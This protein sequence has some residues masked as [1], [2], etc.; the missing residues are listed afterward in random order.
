[1]L[2]PRIIECQCQIASARKAVI[3][4]SLMALLMLSLSCRAQQEKRTALPKFL[5]DV[6]SQRLAYR[7]EPDASAPSG[8]EIQEQ[9]IHPAVGG[10]FDTRRKDEAL[11]RTI[12]SPD[13]QRVLAVYETADK[14]PGEFRIDLYNAEGNFL[15]NLTPPELSGAFSSSVKWSPDGQF[16]AFLGIQDTTPPPIPDLQDPLLKAPPGELPT[17][18]VT[19]ALQPVEVFNTEQ[20]YVCNRDGFDLKAI[21]KRPGLIYFY[22]AWSPSDHTLVALAC[23]E[24]EWN[25]RSPE[26][27]PVGRPRLVYLTG[28]ERLLDDRL[29]EALPVWSPD[30]AKVATAFEYELA[31]YDTSTDGPTSAR[32]PLREP[33][34]A[35]SVSYDRE[36]IASKVTTAGSPAANGY[37]PLSFN[38]VVRLFWLQPERVY[39]QTGFV[40]IYSNEPVSKHLRWHAIN[41]SPQAAELG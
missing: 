5:R 32:I 8:S 34:L 17:P 37:D 18:A 24:D 23:R 4:L 16:I 40:R 21:T 6:P 25:S 39:I 10:D 3:C 19:P 20:I 27:L 38:P 1:M 35:A 13:K 41:L 33:I 29:T 30:S 14:Q 11:L 26:L 2:R 12:V 22:L 36:H 9:T 7:F 15:R 31:I 28:F